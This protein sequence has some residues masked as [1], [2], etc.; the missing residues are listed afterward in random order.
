MCPGCAPES[1]AVRSVCEK[2]VR[3]G[4]RERALAEERSGDL[5]YEK[6][7]LAGQASGDGTTPQTVLT[8]LG[9]VDLAG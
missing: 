2:T 7:D 8:E 3:G 4:C 1:G 6:H 5:G 9:A